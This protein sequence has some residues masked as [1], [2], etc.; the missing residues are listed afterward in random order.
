[1]FD[2][3]AAAELFP[4][5]SP[6][7]SGQIAYRRFESAAHALKFAMEDLP[8][9]LLAGTFLEVNDERL[10]AKQIRELYEDEGFPLP[11]RRRDE[12]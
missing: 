1:M 7:G 6:K 5:R 11:R 2:Y 10:G 4:Q 8:P 12:Y 3:N 9:P